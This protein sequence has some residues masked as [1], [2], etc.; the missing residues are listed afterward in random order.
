MKTDNKEDAELRLIKAAKHLRALY[1]D[2]KH[3]DPP[4]E[5]R[6]AWKELHDATK[7]LE[8]KRAKAKTTTLKTKF[9]CNQERILEKEHE[10]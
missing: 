8:R 1:E 6:Q 7:M 5:D 3:D 10:Q 2:D 9:V 4:S